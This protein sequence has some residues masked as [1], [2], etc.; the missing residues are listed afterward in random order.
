MASFVD[1]DPRQIAATHGLDDDQLRHLEADLRLEQAVAAIE[2]RA[3]VVRMRNCGVWEYE[4]QAVK[5]WV[6]DERQART[7]G[8]AGPRRT[9]DDERRVV[10]TI[11]AAVRRGREPSTTG[12]DA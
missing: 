3:P 12:G 11:G 8:K 4:E 2:G 9:K 6:A 7:E 10:R 5:P 1:I